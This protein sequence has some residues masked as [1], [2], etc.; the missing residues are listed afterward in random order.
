[1]GIRPM[2]YTVFA[3]KAPAT[4][5]GWIW[6]AAIVLTLQTVLHRGSDHPLAGIREARGSEDMT[7]G[8]RRVAGGVAVMFG[9]RC[10]GYLVLLLITAAVS[11]NVEGEWQISAAQRATLLAGLALIP[12]F[13]FKDVVVSFCG[14]TQDLVGHSDSPGLR[15]HAIA[16]FLV[17]CITT[18]L[19][20]ILPAKGESRPP[21]QSQFYFL[22][23]AMAGP[24]MGFGAA[25]AINLVLKDGAGCRRALVDGRFP[26]HL[27]PLYDM[28]D[29]DRSSSPFF[30]DRSS[31]RPIQAQI[32]FLVL[33]Y[34]LSCGLDLG[35]TF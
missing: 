1:M 6:K 32:E 30:T 22:L 8:D 14:L 28:L 4:V 31:T 10:I 35:R 23:R 18:A 24:S 27:R 2:L 25:Y 11:R 21:L 3:S 15:V 12:A 34:C 29:V 19:S 13:A 26:A 16:A 20:S 7:N 9:G 17:V 5:V 33:D